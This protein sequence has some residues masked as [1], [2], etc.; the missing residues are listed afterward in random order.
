MPDKA[1]VTVNVNQTNNT[2]TISPGYVIRLPM[3]QS[4]NALPSPNDRD[5]LTIDASTNSPY[6]VTIEAE[7][8]D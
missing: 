4:T 8:N 6:A 5:Q 7:A 3:R 1:S 2:A